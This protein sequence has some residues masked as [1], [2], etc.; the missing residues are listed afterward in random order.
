[1]IDHVVA[2]RTHEGEFLA[3]EDEVAQAI[4]TDWFSGTSRDRLL[5]ENAN[6]IGVGIEVTQDGDVYATGNLC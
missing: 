1:V 2:G 5:Y 3:T 6:Q 4:V